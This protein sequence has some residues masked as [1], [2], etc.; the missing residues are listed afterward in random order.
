[1][2]DGGRHQ[3]SKGI[4]GHIDCQVR[5]IDQTKEKINKNG[6]GLNDPRKGSGLAK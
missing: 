5:A 2:Q 4:C 1:M 3:K 6:E